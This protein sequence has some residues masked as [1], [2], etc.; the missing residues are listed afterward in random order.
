[1]LLDEVVGQDVAVKS[2]RGMFAKGRFNRAILL[3][4]AYGSGKT[5][6]ARMI[7]LYRNC[8]KPAKNG[9]P[10]LK[11]LSCVSMSLREDG[12]LKHPDV[13]E[14]NMASTRGIDTIRDL[15]SLIRNRP[16]FNSRIIV[17]DEV[18]MLTPQAQNAILKPLEEPPR[19]TTFILATTDAQKLIKTIR[20]RC[21]N[22]QLRRVTPDACSKLLRRV[23]KAEKFK[24]E[25]D[26]ALKIAN[27]TL[28]HPRDALNTLEQVIH[29][30]SGGGEKLSKV[31]PRVIEEAM[32]ASPEVVAFKYLG[33]VLDGNLKASLRLAS[34]TSRADNF[35][36]NAVLACGQVVKA[37]VDRTIA[38][39]YYRR[40]FDPIVKSDPKLSHVEGVFRGLMD[41]YAEAK[42]YL[43]QDDD[44][45][46]FITLRL[47]NMASKR[48]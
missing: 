7:A 29:Y 44:L 43:Q 28:G 24:L 23:A 36:A 48:R 18:H 1:M 11:C 17:L 3:S 22:I 31:L 39:P 45:L 16:R 8:M 26:Q 27:A 40:F 12:T 32:E 9:D 25:D 20:S 46:T 47:T 10:C 13:I 42:S 38:E 30:V 34:M 2:L 5:T 33:F 15:Q 14:L 37:M 35:M 4:G 19:G 41:G 6:L 21:V